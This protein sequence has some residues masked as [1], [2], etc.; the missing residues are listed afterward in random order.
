MESS[1]PFTVSI[2][3][4]ISRPFKRLAQYLYSLA[5][6]RPSILDTLP[7]EIL[8]LISDHLP[9]ESQLC[10]S[11]VCKNIL[12]ALPL[13]RIGTDCDV[14]TVGRFLD[15]LTRNPG[16]PSMLLCFSCAKLYHW[17]QYDG[18]WEARCRH[19][20]YRFPCAVTWLRCSKNETSASSYF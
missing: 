20:I 4:T 12:S 8:A 9:V 16:F 10:L 6:G 13:E 14:N 2:C 11:L 1:K 15:M 19:W 5:K 17:R 7:T 3:G 18:F